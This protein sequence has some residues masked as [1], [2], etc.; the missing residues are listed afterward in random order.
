MKKIICLMLLLFITGFIVKAQQ[1]AYPFLD[2]SLTL[3]ERVNDLVNRMT[4]DE[5]V[6]QM[7]Y[8]APAIERLG[9]PAYNW[10]SGCTHGVG[11]T[12]D[13]VTVYPQSIA[14]AATFNKEE[15]LVTSTQ[16]SDEVRAL[17]HKAKRE[18][19]FGE[20]YYGLTMWDPN[21]NIFRDPRWGRGH[22]TYGED[23]YLM[24]EMGLQFIKG[25][26]GNDPKY[27]K[28]SACAKHFAVHS[29][30]EYDRHA[31]N[32]GVSS[33]DL[34]DTYLPAFRRLIVDGKV[35]SVMCAYN[36]LEGK[37][38][39]GYD[40][41]M[42]DILRDKFGFKGYVTS[43]C[44]AIADFWN[45]HKTHEGMA[46]AS[47]DA[48]L[49]GT[50]LECGDENAYHTLAESVRKGLI[51]ERDIDDCLKRLFLIRFRLGMFDKDE[52][53]PYAK[54]ST[55][56]VNCDKHKQQALKMARESIV[57]M[58]NVKNTLPLKKSIKSIAVIGPNADNK[59]TPLANYNGMPEKLITPLAGIKAKLPNAT[60]IYDEVCYPVVNAKDIDNVNIKAIVDKAKKADVI[61]FVGGLNA[62][63]EGESGDAGKVAYDGFNG[64]DR[65]TIQLPVIQTK[66]LK[67]LH[68]T[69]KPVVFVMMTGS[70]IAIPWETEELSAIVNAWYG[71][72]AI[73]EALADVLF[74][75][76]NPSG[77][78]PVTFYKSD[79]DL[80]HFEDYSMKNRTYRYLTVEAL[81]PFGHGLSYTSFS[82]SNIKHIPEI[83]TDGLLK[84]TVD[85]S[86]SG[87][88]DGSEVT[89]L[90]ISHSTHR[91][92]KPIRS[93][94]GFE[95]IF[96]RKGETKTVEFTLT[97]KELSLV[98]DSGQHINVAD[99]VNISIGGSQ[100]IGLFANKCI[101]SS[102][103]IS[104][105]DFLVY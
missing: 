100:P 41:L 2:A 89:Q 12:K 44:G 60:I 31:F 73:G 81:Y 17:H 9:I 59:I 77:K 21:I 23:P 103:T 83:R 36:R 34:W 42:Q 7:V 67:A 99:K 19:R 80:P 94:V 70:A 85:I 6:Q 24:G 39:C 18:G 66:I 28:T 74:G 65:T 47:I 63:L 90:Y 15:M 88:M 22:E 87:S 32:T 95:K 40:I 48:I 97:P 98:N 27:L 8:K 53:V 13:I 37:P 76:Y 5:K 91:F 72:Q 11:R 96:L 43:D 14:L 105:E 10:W 75:D 71:G 16:I 78:L 49:S 38:C 101:M 61:V 33:Y 20:Q 51:R 69:G 104:G 25:L 64:G 1:V 68:T 57:L 35:S 93:L 54:I 52:I 26:E 50:D 92:K 82:Y 58:K 56:I 86:N 4:L 30:P 45:H 3:D 29:G 55:D 84:I 62:E 79:N 102:A 46:D